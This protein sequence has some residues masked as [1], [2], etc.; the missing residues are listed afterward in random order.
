M[1]LDRQ[2]AR[3]AKI[4]V[5]SEDISF[6]EAQAKLRALT[7]EIVVGGEATS[8]AAHAAILT[9]VSV[10]SRTFVGGVRVTGAIDGPL[11]SALPLGTGSLAEA[12]MLAGASGFEGYSS[13]R[14]CV[15]TNRVPGEVWSVSPWWMGWKAGTASPGEAWWD[16]GDNPLSGIAAGALAVGA[17]FEVA[18]SRCSELRCKADLWPVRAGEEAPNFIESFLP[19]ALWLVGL[20]NL[21]QAFLWALGALPY[22][23]PGDVSL[24]VQDRD[25]VTE[26]NWATSVL[27]KSETYGE[28]KTKVAERWAS[29]KG[30]DLRRID[31]RLL[32]SDR[33]DIDDPRLALSG[34]DKV[35]V[36]KLM[37]EVGFACIVDAGLGR[38][39]S[40]FDKYRVSVFDRVRRIDTH[41]V[42]QT[43]EPLGGDIPDREAYQRLALEIGPCGTAEIGG[44]S[45]AAPYVSALAAAVA[46]S[47]AVA[48]ASGCDC[49]T[50]EVGRLALSVGSKFA[51]LAKI[52]GRGIRH[53]GKPDLGTR[54]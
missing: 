18:R 26:E 52:D 21:G 10:A 9:A 6:D 31:R 43:D 54:S 14:I 29:A 45:V 12:A 49:A 2:I 20:G 34:V 35:E 5:D 39:A 46:I 27:V 1:A 33:L 16:A 51:P 36:R 30:F 24:V 32:A 53:S 22:K 11:N 8:P 15:G 4:L 42:G 3:L 17:A 7:I 38:T 28:L 40:D 48:I 44:A 19:G 47:R 41:F 37:A 50:N 23:N 13:R 25:K